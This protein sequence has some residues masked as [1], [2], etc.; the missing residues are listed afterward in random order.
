[1]ALL[2]GMVESTTNHSIIAKGL[3]D[4]CHK[5]ELCQSY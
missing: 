1:M 5:V 3:V 4:F 2:L